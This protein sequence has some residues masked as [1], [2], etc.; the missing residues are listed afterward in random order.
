MS[1]RPRLSGNGLA[2]LLCCFTACLGIY[3]AGHYFN[4]A[5]VRNQHRAILETSGYLLPLA[6]DNELPAD[7][8]SVTLPTYFGTE[9][10]ST[11]YRARQQGAPVGLILSPIMARG[12]NGPIE[13]GLGLRDDGAIT[14]LMI[15]RHQ[16]TTGLGDQV[17]QD[18]SPWLSGL[19]GYSLQ[20]LPADAWALRQDGGAFDAISGATITQRAVLR[21]VEHTLSYYRLQREQLLLP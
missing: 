11:V 9:A 1:V 19:A 12:Y 2:L 21:A 17:H 14:G 20:N 18:N 8:I 3:A 13:L 10:L 5:I 4:D 16:E 15:L 7:H 6:H